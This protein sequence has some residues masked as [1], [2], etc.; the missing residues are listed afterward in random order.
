MG[1]FAMSE[2]Y[3]LAGNLSAAEMQARRMSIAIPT[4]GHT[5]MVPTRLK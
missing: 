2:Q 4:K 3:A 1:Q 5:E